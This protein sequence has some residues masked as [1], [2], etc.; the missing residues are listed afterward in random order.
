MSVSLKDEWGLIAEQFNHVLNEADDNNNRRA[1]QSKQEHPH[2]NVLEKSEHEHLCSV[3][4]KN[5]NCTRDVVSTG[6]H[7]SK[8]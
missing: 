4:L 5:P 8:M 6:P 2:Q 7:F 3:S 1:N